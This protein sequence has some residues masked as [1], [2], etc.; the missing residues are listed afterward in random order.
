MRG[1]GHNG[2]YFWLTSAEANLAEVIGACPE[3][4]VGRRVAITS[5]DSGPL[6][7]LTEA[8][9]R[10]GWEQAGEI[11]VSPTVAHASEL[12]SDNYD[13]WYVFEGKL[14]EFD[15]LEVFVNYGGFSPVTLAER[16][17][18]MKWDSTWESLRP[19]PFEDALLERF[20][21]TIHRLEPS[22]YIADGDLLTVVTRSELEWD[23]VREE[24][25]R[26]FKH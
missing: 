22:V 19:D 2:K 13:E 7:P 26:H 20:W 8:E 17:A 4:V 6:L 3:L 11:A 23:C 16:R 5:F 21:A 1:E 18:E 14:P 15:D 24:L 10:A 9:L 12:P 25:S